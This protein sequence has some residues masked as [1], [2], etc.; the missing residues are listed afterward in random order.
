MQ[1][2]GGCYISLAQL[3]NIASNWELNPVTRR[4]RC[5]APKTKEEP[6]PDYDSE[7]CETAKQISALCN[8]E[9]AVGSGPPAKSAGEG[10]ASD[11][12]KIQKGGESEES[13]DEDE[14]TVSPKS[15]EQI[16]ATSS[17]EDIDGDAN[18]TVAGKRDEGYDSERFSG[19]AAATANNNHT[20]HK[21]HHHQQQQ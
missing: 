11:E 17:T 14:T 19:G 18:D 20:K 1:L 13:T 10:K 16:I 4:I 5:K 12:S 6:Y 7:E 9:I 21:H 15:G 8:R 2:N 3:D